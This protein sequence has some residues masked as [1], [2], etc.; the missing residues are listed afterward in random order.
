MSPELGGAGFQARPVGPQMTGGQD[1][2]LSGKQEAGQ[3]ISPQQSVTSKPPSLLQVSHWMEQ[4]GSR[5]LQVL[6]PRDGS[7]ETVEK[8]HAEF[9]DF[10]L[11]AV[12]RS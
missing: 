10:F 3:G 9:E 11:Q 1:L 8:A 7:L 12:V 6:T 4:E 5:C 2:S